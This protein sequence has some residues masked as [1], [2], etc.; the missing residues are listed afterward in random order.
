VWGNYITSNLYGE[1]L[2]QEW[3]ITGNMSCG[4]SLA[5]GKKV[6]FILNSASIFLSIIRENYERDFLDLL[7]N[8]CLSWSFVL[9]W[10]GV[11]GGSWLWFVGV[12][13]FQQR[14]YREWKAS[15]C[16]RRA[17][18]YDIYLSLFLRCNCETSVYY[19][20]AMTCYWWM[21]GEAPVSGIFEVVCT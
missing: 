9:T 17:D 18:R 7:S 8:I 6:I 10:S 20:V 15:R 21:T 1:A 3:A 5:G 12:L 13:Q 16:P 11:S 2:W 19:Y 14:F 4:I